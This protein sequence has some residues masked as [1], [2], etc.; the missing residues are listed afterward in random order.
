MERLRATG[1][2]RD[3]S[4]DDLATDNVTFITDQNHTGGLQ[5]VVELARL[6]D[7]QTTDRVLD[8]G[9]GLGGTPRVLADR[10]GC[11][12]HGV[13]LT[14]GRYDDAVELTQRVGLQH[15]VTLSRGDFLD[16]C[17]PEASFDIII[18]QDTLMHFEDL[19]AALRKCWNL[20]VENGKLII[21]DGFLRRAP[22]TE[23][24]RKQLAAAW[25]QWNGRFPPVQEWK[26]SLRCCGLLIQRMEDRTN[27]AIG[28]YQA[29][30]RR[31]IPVNRPPEHREL[32]GWRLG[33]A[34]MRSGVIGTMRVVCEK[35]R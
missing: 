31:I 25:D 21:E 35:R 12:C 17:L 22:A 27:E 15:L 28:D 19:S 23:T 2:L 33:H 18:G 13:E 10:Y 11:R 20:L 5:A 9:T 4:E 1:R 6:V 3:L 7:L 16:V 8:I 29:R 26:N 34:L 14:S 30:L 32:S 24:E